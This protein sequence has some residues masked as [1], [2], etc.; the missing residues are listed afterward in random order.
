MGGREDGQSSGD[1]EWGVE[2]LVLTRRLE[3]VDYQI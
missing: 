3:G 1:G 2:C